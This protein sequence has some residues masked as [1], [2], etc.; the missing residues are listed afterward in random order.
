MELEQRVKTLEDELKLLKNE[1]Q[2]TLLDIQEQV[3]IHYYPALRIEETKPSA[4]TVHAVEALRERRPSQAAA[5]APLAAPSVAPPE[6]AA[7]SVRKVFLE[8][9]REA[10]KELGAPG[11]PAEASLVNPWSEWADSGIPGDGNGNG[12]GNGNSHRN[13]NGGLPSSSARDMLT[14]LEWMLNTA[15]KVNGEENDGL[16]ADML[17]RLTRLDSLVDRAGG[18]EEALRLIEEAKLG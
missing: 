6:P 13:G 10:Q 5:S 7:P 15:S 12:H 3:L 18:V 14:L 1:V 9:I 8:E 4:G 2:R 16:S 11:V 17:A